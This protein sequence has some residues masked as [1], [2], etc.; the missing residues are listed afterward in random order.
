VNLLI[1]I[2][3][4]ADISSNSIRSIIWTIT[5]L[6]RKLA[7]TIAIVMALSTT[8]SSPR[9][10]TATGNREVHIL[11]HPKTVSAR[12]AVQ[13]IGEAAAAGA[14]SIDRAA[15]L[16]LLVGR[17]GL[18]GVR[19]SELVQQCDLPKPTVRR[20]LLALV[21]AGLLDQE[22][23][24]RR[25]QLGPESYVLG[26]LASKRFGIHPISLRSLVRLCE[27]TGDTAYLSVPRDVYSICL[28]REEGSYPIRTHALHAG[29]RHPLGVGAG[30]LALLA[31]LQDNE[32][33]QVLSANSDILAEKYP[34]YSPSVLRELVRQ[35]RAN[36]Y[37]LNP[38]MTLQGSWA[39][40]V[41]VRGSDGRPVGALSL[42]A[43][44]SRMDEARQG[45]L[46]PLLKK[47]AAWIERRLRELSGPSSAPLA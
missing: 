40:G 42:A 4:D 20:M 46:A 3:Q 23:E 10:N 28:H 19:L 39:V 36:G 24:S 37:A 38:G 8:F 13:V 32:V 21:R 25:Y 2:P 7:W 6:Y 31:A 47:E 12:K 14:Q 16:L 26:T 44:E 5:F 33:E 1:G 22:K 11:E 45:E 27:E 9:E 29:D 15:T 30:S 34:Q 43:I 18:M 41:A 17:A 35:A